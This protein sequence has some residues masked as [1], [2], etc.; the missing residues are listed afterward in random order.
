MAEEI[1]RKRPLLGGGNRALCL[2]VCLLVGIVGRKAQY[3]VCTHGVNQNPITAEVIDTLL[4][5][6]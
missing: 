6:S 1:K 3:V 5:V 2:F 4:Q